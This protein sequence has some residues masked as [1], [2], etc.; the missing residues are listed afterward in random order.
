MAEHTER[1]AEDGDGDIWGYG[2]GRWKCL[3]NAGAAG[4][5]E[6][7]SESYPPVAFYVPAPASCTVAFDLS[8]PDALHVLTTALGDYA[9]HERPMAEREG[10]SESRTRWAD[11][12]ERFRDQ[13][14]AA[15]S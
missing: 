7:L 9:A 8:D 2:H 12:A 6:S 13:A 1:F 15:G 14:E 10:A 3:T 5:D 4:D 11:L